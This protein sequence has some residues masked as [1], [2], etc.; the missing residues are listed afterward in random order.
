MSD[1]EHCDAKWRSDELRRD[2]LGAGEACICRQQLVLFDDCGNERLC[3]IYV[4]GLADAE[5]ECTHVELP[6]GDD[7]EEDRSAEGSDDDH[8]RDIRTDHQLATI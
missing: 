5:E 4:H 1:V 8:A 3:G 7:L 6:D 2:N